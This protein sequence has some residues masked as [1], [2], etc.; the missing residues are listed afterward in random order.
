M[1]KHSALNPLPTRD[2]LL[3][4]LENLNHPRWV[5][6]EDDGTLSVSL[7]GGWERPLRILW[8]TL[9]GYRYVVSWEWD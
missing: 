4:V 9:A 3:E 7:V 2:Q 1:N 6:W 8:I 5:S